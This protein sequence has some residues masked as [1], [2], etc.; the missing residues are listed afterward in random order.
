[1]YVVPFSRQQ[2]AIYMAGHGSKDPMDGVHD[3]HFPQNEI[4][5]AELAEDLVGSGQADAELAKNLAGR[6]EQLNN[7][8]K[9]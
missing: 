5:D 9:R 7:S 1:L 4:L 2:A 3:A 8:N 6:Q